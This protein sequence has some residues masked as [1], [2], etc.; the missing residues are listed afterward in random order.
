MES[1]PGRNAGGGGEGRVTTPDQA[2]L[3]FSLANSAGGGTDRFSSREGARSSTATG[4]VF[5]LR[6]D[7]EGEVCRRL[8]ETCF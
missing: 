1:R 5:L 6:V 4:G 2:G 7:V 3:A 8:V